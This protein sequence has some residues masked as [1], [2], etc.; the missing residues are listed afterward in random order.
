[1]S[2]NA[3]TSP[4]EVAPSVLDSS[5]IANF[6]LSSDPEVLGVSVGRILDVAQLVGWSGGDNG[7]IMKEKVKAF[8]ASTGLSVVDHIMQG[9]PVARLRPRQS[10]HICCMMTGA[11][12]ASATS[13]TGH[14][15]SERQ[16]G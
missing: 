11:D 9:D 1:M 15:T 2:G 7:Y 14:S 12:L 16:L 6:A 8:T 3:M 10:E 4:V 5:T 13:R